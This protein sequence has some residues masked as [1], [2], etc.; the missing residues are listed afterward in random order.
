MFNPS[1]PHDSGSYVDLQKRMLM[2]LQAAKIDEQVLDILQKAFERE[3]AAEHIVLSKSERERLFGQS[4]K[5]VFDS[6][7]KKFEGSR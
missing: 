4:M 5:A 7:L 1:D 2:R 6:L 3:L